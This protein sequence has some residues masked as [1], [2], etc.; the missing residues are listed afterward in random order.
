LVSGVWFRAF[1]FGPVE[2]KSNLNR[3]VT[4]KPAEELLAPV[5]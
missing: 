5:Q 2:E 1:G 4:S 3:G